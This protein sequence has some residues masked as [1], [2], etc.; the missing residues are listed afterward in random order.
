M[1][2]REIDVEPDAEKGDRDMAQTGEHGPPRQR[3]RQ[4]NPPPAARH[5]GEMPAI[6]PPTRPTP[7][8]VMA[9]I[10]TELT[11]I[12]QDLT[13]PLAQHGVDLGT[14]DLGAAVTRLHCGSRVFQQAAR[15]AEL[16]TPPSSPEFDQGS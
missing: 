10:A 5:T 2:D 6:M 8:Q 12:G 14:G 16:L 4:G 7:E 9:E 3:A 11:R 13:F 1:P 15:L